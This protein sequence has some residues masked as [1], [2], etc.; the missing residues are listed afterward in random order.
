[1]MYIPTSKDAKFKAKG[2][3]DTFGGRSIKF[4]GARI[5]NTLKHNMSTLIN[6]GTLL[7]LGIVGVWVVV[8][9]YVGNKNAA[10]TKEGKIV[11]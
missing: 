7:S 5:T 9:I 2:W 6:F 10:L 1:M 4:L 8:A 11:E 3:V